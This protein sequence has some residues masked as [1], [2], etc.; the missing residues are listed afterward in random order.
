MNTGRVLAVLVA[1]SVF[2]ALRAA[3]Q[4]THP[5]ADGE[6][7]LAVMGDPGRG[8]F[9]ATTPAMLRDLGYRVRVVWGVP[10]ADPAVLRLLPTLLIER[11]HFTRE[12]YDALRA[13]ARQSGGLKPGGATAPVRVRLP[14]RPT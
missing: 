11:Q 13:Y 14:P 12:Q 2:P 8:E 7:S 5:P 6:P 1:S 10:P 4:W 3:E 9:S